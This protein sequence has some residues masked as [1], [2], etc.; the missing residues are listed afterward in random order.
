M[1]AR[2][3]HQPN[4]KGPAMQPPTKFKDLAVGDEF[5]FNRNLES[6]L[7]ADLK[8]PGRI[9][10]RKVSRTE[11]ECAEHGRGSVG[12]VDAKVWRG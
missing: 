6:G 7:L 11:W 3:P 2:A 9:A 8:S 1:S 10:Y 5:R 12:S 4:P